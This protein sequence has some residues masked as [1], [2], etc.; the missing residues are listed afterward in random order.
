MQTSRRH[1]LK[2]L[3]GAALGTFAQAAATGNTTLLKGGR[4]LSL[5][6]KIGD[7][8]KADVLIQGSKIMA[9]QPNIRASGKVIDASNMIV[10]PGFIDTHRHA[11][12]APLRNILPNGL[13]SDYTRDITGTAR[14]A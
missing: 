3:F 5:D 4:V 13:L 8:E 6:P 10:M 11:W 9:V 2:S 14:A 1:F 7:F 12:E